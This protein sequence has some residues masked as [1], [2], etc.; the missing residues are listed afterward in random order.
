MSAVLERPAPAG[1]REARLLLRATAR[2]RRTRRVVV[3]AVLAALAVGTVLLTLSVGEMSVGVG[4]VF[5]TALGHGDDLSRLVLV[6]FR[7]PRVLMA[8]LVGV[9]FALSGGLFQSVLRNPLASPDIIGISQGAS[10]GAVVALLVLDLSGPMVSVGAL[11]GAAVVAG[12]NLL[13]A[14]RGG[15]SGHRFVLCGIALAFVA[16]SVLSYVLT[17]V[18]ARDAQ[19]AMVWLSGSVSAADAE[20]YTRLALVLVVLVPLALVLG[21][22]LGMLE[23]GDEAATAL[24]VAAPRLRLAAILLGV[25]LAAVATAA[26]GPVAFVA[27]TAAPIARRLVADGRLSLVATALVGVVI[28]VVADLLAQ[29]L[30]DGVQVPVGVVT[31][32]IGGPYLIWLLASSRPL[33]RSA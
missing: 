7:L 31:G 3:N 26:A 28:M 17:R 16:T 21:R 11:V 25:A 2:A 15:L 8:A 27:L 14:S 10:V 13:L 4:D 32:V 19:T 24:G 29:H 6:E 18:D 20:A 5:A 9:A 23:M 30:I 22:P 12:T 1:E 33:R